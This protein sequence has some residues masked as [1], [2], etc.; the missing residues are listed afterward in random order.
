MKRKASRMDNLYDAS[1]NL[2][3][4]LIPS[5]RITIH[6][7]TSEEI[8][9][10]H[11][12]K[13]DIGKRSTTL[14]DMITGDSEAEEFTLSLPNS[15]Y[16]GPLILFLKTGVFQYVDQ[17][18]TKPFAHLVMNAAHLGCNEIIAQLKISF[19][20]PLF[21]SKLVE[22]E[23]FWGLVSDDVF[24][25]LMTHA[26]LKNPIQIDTY[27]SF[28][29]VVWALPPHTKLLLSWNKLHKATWALPLIVNALQIPD[30][31]LYGFKDS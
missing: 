22:E 8:F 7:K 4:L 31:A 26:I 10:F 19:S 14:F 29:V 21:I 6:L 20:E 2:K 3:S 11:T 25:D 12:D 1:Y 30:G 15:K 17:S 23:E 9:S 24:K 18:P 28:G 27:T 16:L 13:D 5:K